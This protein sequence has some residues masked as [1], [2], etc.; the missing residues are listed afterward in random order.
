MSRQDHPRLQVKN[1]YF[2]SAWSD[3]QFLVT[4]LWRTRNPKTHSERS[5]YE[6]SGKSKKVEKC[7]VIKTCCRAKLQKPDTIQNTEL[8]SCVNNQGRVFFLFFQSGNTH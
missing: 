8:V 4:F 1:A 5:K 2:G 3:V 7:S 6:K